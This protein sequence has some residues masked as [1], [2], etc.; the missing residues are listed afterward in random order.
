MVL[1]DGSLPASSRPSRSV[2]TGSAMTTTTAI[3]ASAGMTGWRSRNLAHRAQNVPSCSGDGP[4]A[5]SALRSLRLSTFSP[6]KPSIAGSSVRDES[7]VSSTVTVAETAT[8]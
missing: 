8:P 3:A 4:S 1:P 6:T 7:I 2:K 5:A